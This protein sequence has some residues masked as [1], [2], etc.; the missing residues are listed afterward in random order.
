MND[1]RRQFEC[2][3]TTYF[4]RWDRKHQ[5]TFADHHP[6]C[7]G[8]GYCANEDKQIIVSSSDCSNCGMDIDVAMI[9]EI[10]HAVTA[11]YHDKKWQRR[12]EKAALKADS[13]GLKELAEGIRK[14]YIAYSDPERSCAYTAEVVYNQI[15]DAVRETQGEV[16]FEDIV[17]FVGNGDCMP[18]KQLLAKYKKARKV[19][20]NACRDLDSSKKYTT[21]I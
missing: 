9:H 4:S 19:Y 13:L 16:S 8:P 10:A 18:S 3:R 7:I 15:E 5:W 6:D 17:R 14:D 21:A 1:L 2:M 20:E 11:T 12:M